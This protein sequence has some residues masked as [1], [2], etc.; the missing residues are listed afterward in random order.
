MGHVRFLVFMRDKT[1]SLSHKFLDSDEDI[2]EDAD[3][4][5]TSDFGLNFGASVIM[6]ESFMIDLKYGMGLTD[7]EGSDADNDD[8]VLLNGCLSISVGYMFGG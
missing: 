6:A 7:L 4:I 1:N 2:N 8:E 5:K 3:I